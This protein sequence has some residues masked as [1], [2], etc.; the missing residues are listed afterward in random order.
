MQLSLHGVEV[1][2]R[3]GDIEQASGD[4]HLGDGRAGLEEAGV[5]CGSSG[6]VLEVV[7]HIR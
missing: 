7:E 6:N 1:L 5:F 3:E 4:L 2:Q